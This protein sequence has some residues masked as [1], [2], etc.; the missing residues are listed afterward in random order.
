MWVCVSDNFYVKII[1]EK[2]LERVTSKKLENLEMDTLVTCLQKEI[3][4]KRY[5]IVLDDVWNEN[6]EKWSE[7]QKNLMG[8]AIGSRILVTTRSE[9][10]AKITQSM[11][12]HVLKGLDKQHAWSLFK[13]MAF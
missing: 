6:R 4:G 9:L 12:L 13:K 3:N 2:I 7:L 8:G 11:Q 5:L 1:V 10:V